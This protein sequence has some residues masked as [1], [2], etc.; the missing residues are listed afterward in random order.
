[1]L[2]VG[3]IG[4]T[5]VDLAVCRSEQDS[6]S[7]AA[8]KRFPSAD[9]PSLEA[10][11]NEFIA[12]VDLPVTSACFA[13]A[14]P[15]SEGS[16]T[17]TN[18]PWVV[19]ESAL[20]AALKLEGVRLLNDVEAIAAAVP[21]LRPADVRVLQQGDPVPGGAIAVIAAGTGLGEAYL[22]W[23]GSRYRAHPSEGSHVDFGPTSP[24]ET[25]LLRFLQARLGRVSY[26]RVCAGRSIPD[27]Y[28]FIRDEEAVPES[29]RLAAELAQARDR[30]PLIMAAALDAQ[31]PDP[32]S[33]S[34]LKM[35][36]SILGS[37]A[38]NLTLSVV[39]TGGVYLSGGIVQRMLPLAAE[40]DALFLSAF[41]NKGRLTP[42]LKQIPIYAI[43]ESVALQGAA[44]HAFDTTHSPRSVTA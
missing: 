6:W 36:V 34:A 21:H 44:F 16:A 5:K 24:R 30:T 39:A 18:L 41:Y 25:S 12:E 32:L 29:P 22:T 20:Q 15:V 13:V 27:L 31:E 10:I 4:G 42:L 23:D 35:F 7:P 19:E 9:Y 11:A 40:Q 1:M 3:D 8:K 17:L 26:E 43:L 38:G 37:E 14:G 2:L 33:L 28:E